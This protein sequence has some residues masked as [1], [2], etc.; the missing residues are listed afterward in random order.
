MYYPPEF[1]RNRALELARLIK[2]AYQQFAAFKQGTPWALEGNYTWVGEVSYHTLVSFDAGEADELTAVDKEI[3]AEPFSFAP[4]SLLGQDVPMGFVATRADA[5]YLVFRGTVTLQEW[6]FDAEIK[7]E[8]YRLR[9]WGNVSNGFLKIYNR[10][11][12]SVMSNLNGLEPER[13]L[14]IA[15]HSLGGALSLLA[16]PDVAATTAFK[17]PRLYNFGCP[18]VGDNDFVQAYNHLPGQQTFRVVNTSDL[19]TAVPLPV[20]VPLVPSG[21]YSHVDTPVDFTYQ[22]D[23]LVLNHSMDTYITALSG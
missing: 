2:Q 12:E 7:V 18:R 13:P 22:G 19:V 5:A 20:S 1:D 14:F 8:P 10:C 15:G 21:N 17:Q 3:Q 23:S 9:Q 6:L 4:G 16:L 11:R